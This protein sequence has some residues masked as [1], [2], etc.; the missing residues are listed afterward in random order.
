MTQ[1]ALLLGVIVALLN[2]TNNART[3]LKDWRTRRQPAPHP[4][5]YALEVQLPAALRDIAQA[6][7]EAGGQT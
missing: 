7:R 4:L 2:I 5:A 6:I 1:I 3:L